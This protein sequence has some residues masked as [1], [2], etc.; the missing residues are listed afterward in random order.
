MT[1]PILLGS[2]REGRVSD[3]AATYVATFL[4]ERGVTT[5]II[6]PRDYPSK[7]S[8]E[9]SNPEPWATL[10]ASADGLVIV[11]PEYNHGYPAPLK[12]M[13]DSLHLQYAQKPV[14]IC[15]TSG[16]GLGGAVAELLSRNL[17]TPQ[18]FIGMPDRFGES[19][20]P[21]ELLTK[22][23]MKSS[24][25]VEAAKKVISRKNASS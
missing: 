22:Y 5:Q 14:A 13:I 21:D 19:G 23:H 3:R 15:G 4:T 11:S 2:S 12:T 18:E 6:D 8:M 25:I 16:G 1:I 9:R 24:D 10:M 7:P 17:P 20:E